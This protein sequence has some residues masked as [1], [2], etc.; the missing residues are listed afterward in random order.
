MPIKGNA[1]QEQSAISNHYR[2]SNYTINTDNLQLL[3]NQLHKI[4]KTGRDQYIA[5]CPSHKDKS[6]SLAIR[7]DNG[8]ILL[9]CFAGCSTHEIVSSIG[10]SLSDLF[11]KESSYSKPTKT[12]FPAVSVLRCIQAEA[13]I[14]VTA[15]C[16]I[17]NG[18]TLSPEDLQR[19][20]LA[21]SR[22]W[23]CYE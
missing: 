14:V 18:R 13:L 20:V 3:L 5:C 8:K 11:P 21:G 15:A 2:Q 7:D 6:P 17:A 10:L 1:L 9:H 4:K 23:A 19:L 12:P 16:N 22:I